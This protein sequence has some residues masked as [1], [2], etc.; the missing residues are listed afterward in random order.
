MSKS[1]DQLRDENRVLKQQ[2]E[3][4]K[5]KTQRQEYLFEI[6][7]SKYGYSGKKP[8][9]DRSTNYTEMI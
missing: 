9:W 7:A 1:R 8:S 2:Q 6:F 3:Q 5:T 4:S